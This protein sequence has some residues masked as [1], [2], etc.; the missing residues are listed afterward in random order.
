MLATTRESLAVAGEARYRLAPLAL[1]DPEDLAKAVK[2]ES[3]ALF[4][5][6]P[7]SADAQ[8]ALTGET[9]PIVARLDGMPLWASLPAAF[10]PSGLPGAQAAS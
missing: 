9:T 5:D 7:R 1:P 8:F 2:A 10:Q 4:T 6:R 3:V